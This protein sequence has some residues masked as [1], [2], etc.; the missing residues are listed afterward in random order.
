MN[1]LFLRRTLPAL[2]VLTVMISITMMSHAAVRKV[3]RRIQPVY[4]ELAKRMHIGG[5]VRVSATIAADGTV[6]EAHAIRGNKLLA[7]AAENAIKRWKFAPGDGA[8]TETID[9]DFVEND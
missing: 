8:S 2:F 4:P 1:S 5:T 9:I 6:T 7:P 3:E